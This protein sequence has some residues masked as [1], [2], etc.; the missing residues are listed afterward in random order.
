MSFATVSIVTG[1]VVYLSIFFA[2]LNT[3]GLDEARSFLNGS[4]SL[5]HNL[6]SG[7]ENLGSGLITLLES[8]G[9]GIQYAMG[10]GV[11]RLLTAFASTLVILIDGTARSVTPVAMFST[12]TLLAVIVWL[13]HDRDLVF[14]ISQQVLTP[15]SVVIERVWVAFSNPNNLVSYGVFYLMIFVVPKIPDAIQ[16]VV[17][18]SHKL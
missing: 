12:I 8:F 14:T 11:E 13:I 7:M 3:G 2:V 18:K 5:L 9:R 16:A 17:L 1:G 10:E 15:I 6:G 4:L